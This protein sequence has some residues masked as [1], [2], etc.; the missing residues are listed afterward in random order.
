MNLVKH[1]LTVDELNNQANANLLLSMNPLTNLATTDRNL[2]VACMVTANTTITTS[3]LVANATYTS[4]NIN[5]TTKLK[6][7]LTN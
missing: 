5:P 2:A 7:P 3:N 4:N 1:Q 6:D